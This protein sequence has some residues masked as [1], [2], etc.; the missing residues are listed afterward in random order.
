MTRPDGL[1]CERCHRLNKSCLPGN[2]VRRHN[3]RP[4]NPVARIAQLEGKI[5]DIVS[6]LGA[7]R[8]PNAPRLDAD[9]PSPSPESSPTPPGPMAATGIPAVLPDSPFE[10]FDPSPDEVDE[11][12]GYFRN[13]MIKFFPF[14]YLPADVQLLRRERPFLFLCVIATASKST[15]RKRTLHARIKETLAQRIVLSPNCGGINIDLLLG[16]LTFVA[17]GND[18]LLNGTPTSLSRFT[19][20]AMGLVFELRL[21]KPAPADTNMLPADGYTAGTSTPSTPA[22][23]L[24]E[25]RAVLGCFV[26]SSM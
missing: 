13:H 15:Q 11:C 7:G 5:D 8:G 2:L 25:R 1:G 18:Q 16:L 6:L 20:M 14:L 22:G 17:W 26:M 9:H 19:Q 24:E 4:N 10:A 23:S 12:V 3:A 21:N